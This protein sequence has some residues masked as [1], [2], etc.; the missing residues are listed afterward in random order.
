MDNVQINFYNNTNAQM[1]QNFIIC[2][3]D[4]TSL[5]DLLYIQIKNVNID[6]SNR[7]SDN[8]YLL[9]TL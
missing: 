7:L 9:L 4:S 3:V 1:S 2:A 5:Y 8:A 6:E